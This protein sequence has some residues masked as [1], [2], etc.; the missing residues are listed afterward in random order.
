MSPIIEVKHL[1][2]SYGPVRVLHDVNLSVAAGEVVVIIGASGSGKSTLI[3]CIN[4]LERFGIG[5][6][7]VDGLA[8][9]SSDARSKRN[10]AQ[11]KD[12]R[13]EVG[14]VF[15]QFNLFSHKTVLENVTLAPIQVR[16][17][18]RNRADTTALR[19]LER[20]GLR[21]HVHKYP[22]QLSG[23]QQQRVAIARSL[24]ME[25]RVM[26]FDEPTSALDPELVGE[27]LDV[28]RG[29][30]S[31]GMTMIVVTHEMG[32]AREVADHVVYIDH[33]HVLEEGP[34]AAIFD[35]PQQERTKA[36][37]SRV[38]KH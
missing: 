9:T 24:A 34:P 21:D 23:G 27:V 3:R 22:S 16:K 25:P 15:Q 12:I 32:F 1:S 31:E 35:N 30:A 29:L 8:L 5:S 17:W 28:M 2:K 10:A 6:I 13:R 4:G 19:L 7:V 36:F 11:L 14:M 33:G 38:L 20:V 37:L 18:D 26:L